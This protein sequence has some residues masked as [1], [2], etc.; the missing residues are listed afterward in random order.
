MYLTNSVSRQLL[1]IAT[2][3]W[4]AGSQALCL[5]RSQLAVRGTIRDSSGAAV[6]GAGV[7]LK[8]AATTLH[9]VTDNEGQYE[10]QNVDARMG[11]LLVEASGFAPP[12]PKWN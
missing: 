3:L 2:I 6:S 10:F 1:L 11:I 4:F 7:T 9:A 8:G 5:G 12:E